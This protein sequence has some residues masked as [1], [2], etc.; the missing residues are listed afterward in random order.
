MDT[1]IKW[2]NNPERKYTDGL[3]IYHK[4][5]RSKDKDAFFNSQ[6]NPA[7]GSLHFNLLMQE[8]KNAHRVLL[9]KGH[10]FEEKPKPPAVGKPITTAPLKLAK[11]IPDVAKPESGHTK[12]VFNELVDVKSLPDNLQ[13]K[14]FQNQQIT[15]DLAGLHQQLKSATS[16][17]DRI[18]IAG[19]I[20]QLFSERIA[21]WTDIDAFAG[22]DITSAKPTTQDVQKE[23]GEHSPQVL[24]QK[25]LDSKKRLDTVKINI[26][27]VEKEIASGKLTPSKISSREARLKVWLQEKLDL[28]NVLSQ[29]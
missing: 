1:I 21:N 12:Y 29:V 15:R 11:K 3:A 24:A 14:Y 25:L 17:K 18:V 8:I 9:A 23:V 27:R 16:D 20:E 13:Q 26:S 4:I 28:E 6:S 22:V 19:N 5:K 10:Q 7:P 2:I